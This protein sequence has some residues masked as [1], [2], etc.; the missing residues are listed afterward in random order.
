[1]SCS[2]D[3]INKAKNAVCNKVHVLHIYFC[4]K[5]KTK[6]LDRVQ[7]ECNYVL[8]FSLFI[9]V[10]LGFWHLCALTYDCVP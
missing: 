9:Q 2:Q 4:V 6:L 10:N 7:K 5:E 3:G 1:M 8:D